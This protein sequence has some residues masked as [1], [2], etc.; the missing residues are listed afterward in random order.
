MITSGIGGAMKRRE[1]DCLMS[2]LSPRK[3]ESVL[4]VGCGS[5][6]YGRLI[7]QAG[8]K[9]MCVDI[10][11]KMIDI[12]RGAGLDAEVQDVESLELGRRFDKILC[13]GPL[14]FC[15][16]PSKALANLRRHV[17]NEGCLVLSALNVSIIGFAYYLYHFSHG[18][19]ITLFSL[20]RIAA[21][22]VKAG[23][24]VDVV[25]K[26]TSFLYVIRATPS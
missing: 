5:G 19:R 4:D 3:R 1:T 7:D 25:E 8:A 22:L 18:L 23:F 26:P 17:H 14:E 9:V 13:A 2:L 10:S 6:F 20:R 11:P 21:L 12:V 15:R 16:Q 24:R